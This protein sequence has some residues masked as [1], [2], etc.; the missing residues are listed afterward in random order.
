ML[1]ISESINVTPKISKKVTPKILIADDDPCVVRALVE[2]CTGMGF[3]IE[4]ATNGLQALI[5]ASQCKPD[6][7]VIDVHMPEVDGIQGTL[8]L[9][10]SR[11]RAVSSGCRLSRPVP[12]RG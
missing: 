2:R 10:A 1:S 3:E 7:L 4:T 11:A 9:T 5:K 6:I 8:A 12:S